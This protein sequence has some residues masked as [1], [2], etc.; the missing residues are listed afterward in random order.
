MNEKLKLLV[1]GG[2]LGARALNRVIPET[3]SI[4]PEEIVLEVRHQT[5]RQL[6]SETEA[7]YKELKCTAQLE[8]FIEDMAAAYA[9]ADLVICRSGALTVAELSAAG[10]ASILI[11]FPFAVDDHQT[12]NAQFLSHQGAAL[13]VQEQ[14]L[15][16]DKLCKLLTGF[17][18]SRHHL[19]SMAQQ[20]RSLAKPQATHKVAEYCLEAAYAG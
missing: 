12:A 9:W 1:L 15:S 2:S 13:L 19:L 7:L 6:F 20:A 4:L 17:Y 5:G 18:Q 8:P 3:L 16:S 11:P 14:D 10:V